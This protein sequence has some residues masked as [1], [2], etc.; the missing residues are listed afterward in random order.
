LW[1]GEHVLHGGELPD[2]DEICR[3]VECVSEK[4]IRELSKRLFR[5]DGVRLAM[6]GPLDSRLETQMKAESVIP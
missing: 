3:Q 6:I 1:Y 2:V 5:A 4:H